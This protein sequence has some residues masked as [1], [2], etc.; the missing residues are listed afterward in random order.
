MA[1]GKTLLLKLRYR[2]QPHYSS[3]TSSSTS[4]SLEINLSNPPMAS[5]PADI[6]S[7]DLHLEM[8]PDPLMSTF[9]HE[10][11]NPLSVSIPP[12]PMVPL[13]TAA[14]LSQRRRRKSS[15]SLKRSASTPN[16][17]GHHNSDAGMTLAEKRRNKLGYHRISIACGML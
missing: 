3:K 15:A 7:P 16:V 8:Q 2:P 9:D 5:I 12:P 4:P 13:T 1:V 6:T 17:R 11:G 14:I 10:S